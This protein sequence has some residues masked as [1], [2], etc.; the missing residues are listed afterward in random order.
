MEI[1]LMLLGTLVFPPLLLWGFF[2]VSPREEIVVLRFGKHI[3]TVRERGMRWIHPVGRELRRVST[4]DT[5]LHIPVSTVVDKLGNPIQISAVVVYRVV[6]CIKATLDVEDHHKFISDQ[7][8]AVVKGV[9]ATFPY[10]SPDAD[11]PC[12]KKEDGIVTEAL[13][14]ALQTAVMAAGIEVVSVKFNDLTYSPEIAQAMLMRQQA[15][16]LIDARKTIV[17]G[18]VEIVRDAMERLNAAG[19][20]LENNQRDVL[21]SNLLVVICSGENAQ[22]VVQVG[23]A[24]SQERK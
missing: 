5:T 12:L 3:A 23:A 7:A 19:F 6:D 10:E 22:P 14:R 4:R 20:E 24:P 8:S 15:L 16:A 17:E 18:A 9:A 13:V 2:V 11:K 1:L 21:I